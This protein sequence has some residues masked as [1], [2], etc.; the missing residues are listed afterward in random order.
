MKQSKTDIIPKSIPTLLIILSLYFFVREYKIE[1]MIATI[2]RIITTILVSI[3][4]E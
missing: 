2:P 3:P 4:I 1:L